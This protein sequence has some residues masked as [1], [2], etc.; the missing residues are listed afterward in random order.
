MSQPS[1]IRLLKQ[2]E[3]SLRLTLFDRTSGRLVPTPEALLLYEEVERTF[4]SV[5]KIR[6]I[7]RDI[8]SAN[9][10][11][12]NIASLPLLAL[13]FIPNAIKQF[14]E[15]HPHTRISLNVQMSSKIEEWAAAQQ[16]DFGLAEF[17]FEARSFERQGIEVEEFCRVPHLLA[18]PRG[19]R[20]AQRDIVRPE[21]LAGERFISQ[22]RNTVGRLQ[23]E[24]VFER[25]GIEP[26][27]VIE[28]QIIAVVANLV[29]Q[30]LGVGFVDP[31]TAFDFAD[32]AII[33]VPFEPA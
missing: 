4:V 30:G 10:G 3:S 6:E 16:I 29:A 22:T 26:E 32:K 15:T 7:A 24:K 14:N 23:V 31:F 8:R 27:T 11:T 28:S 17:P 19:H 25:A 13:G 1:V 20:L 12:L 5:D 33:T 2:L 18:V 9:V 21:D